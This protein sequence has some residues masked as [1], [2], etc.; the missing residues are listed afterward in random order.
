MVRQFAGFPG[1][2]ACFHSRDKKISLQ[3]H[4]SLLEKERK[5][6]YPFLFTR[7]L[8]GEQPQ[9]WGEWEATGSHLGKQEALPL[10]QFFSTEGVGRK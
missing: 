8:L 3:L 9:H 6:K 2:K 10:L 5:T 7:L 1:S 4:V